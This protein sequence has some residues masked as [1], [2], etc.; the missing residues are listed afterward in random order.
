[1]TTKIASGEEKTQLVPALGDSWGH[2]CATRIV[3]LL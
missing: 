1:M 3:I 2:T